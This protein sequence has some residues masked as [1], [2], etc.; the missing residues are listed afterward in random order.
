MLASGPLNVYSLNQGVR[1][2]EL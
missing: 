1:L 2:N